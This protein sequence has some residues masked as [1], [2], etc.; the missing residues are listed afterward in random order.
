MLIKAVKELNNQGQTV[1]C[2]IIGEGPEKSKLTKLVEKLKITDSITFQDFYA[3]Q[4]DLYAQIKAS[5]VFALPSSREGFG[6]VAIEANACGKVVVTNISKTNA[7]KEIIN[8]GHNGFIFEETVSAFT[9]ELQ[10]A[11]NASNALEKECV[12][13]A[14][15]Y[16]WD[17]LAKQIVGVY[18][19]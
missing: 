12:M 1:K 4:D 17:K 7:A 5:K 6:M 10:K 8:Y 9:H 14:Q 19:Q 11:L 15:K 13:Y 2:L 3:E 16:D 18:S